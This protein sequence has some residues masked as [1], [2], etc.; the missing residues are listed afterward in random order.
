MEISKEHFFQAA[1]K[2]GISEKNQNALWEALE[3][4]GPKDATISKV[5]YYFGALIVISAMTWFMGLGWTVFGGGGIFLILIVYAIIFILLGSKL[6][7]KKELKIPGGLL[8]TMAVCMTPLAIYG[9]ES[10]FD[11]LPKDS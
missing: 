10:Y 6:W 2:I 3:S 11:Y 1:S 9:L 7:N 5:I 8:I 4:E